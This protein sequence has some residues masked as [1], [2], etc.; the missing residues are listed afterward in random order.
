MYENM[1]LKSNAISEMR[2]GK[3]TQF[4]KLFENAI[5]CAIYETNLA[6]SSMKFRNVLRFGYYILQRNCDYY[7]AHVNNGITKQLNI[8]VFV[9]F[10]CVLM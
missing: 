7:V 2:D 6:Y 4:D 1:A 9:L 8:D 5:N 3:Y 10:D